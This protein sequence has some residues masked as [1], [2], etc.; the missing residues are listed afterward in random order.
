[1]GESPLEMSKARDGRATHHGTKQH[2]VWD[3][4]PAP[5]PA[6]GTEGF[7]IMQSGFFYQNAV[8]NIL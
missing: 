1:M 6:Q 7:K 4:S 8:P 5:P 3:F 2:N